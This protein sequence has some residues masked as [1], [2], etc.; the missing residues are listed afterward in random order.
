[1]SENASA[2]NLVVTHEEMRARVASARVARLGTIGRRGVPH[3]VPLCFVLDDDVL[4]FAV[5]RKPKRGVTLQRLRNAALDPRVSVL[6]DHY[7]EDWSQLWWIRLDG[8]AS[9]LA[10]GEESDSALRLLCSKY[11]QY[12][13]EPPPGP[14]VRIDVE[15]WSGWAPTTHGE[16]GLPL[17]RGPREIEDFVG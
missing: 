4:Y 6:V 11:A 10:P 8:R 5:D 1:M 3:L 12:R 14:V 15:R 2:Q 13:Q 17:P 7:E 16:A 9:A